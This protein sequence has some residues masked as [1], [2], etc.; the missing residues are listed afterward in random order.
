MCMDM[1]ME[2]CGDITETS[3]AA[4]VTRSRKRS[5]LERERMSSVLEA[6]STRAFDCDACRQDC[7]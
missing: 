7:V 1:G 3:S 2:V 6:S 4:V 5:L